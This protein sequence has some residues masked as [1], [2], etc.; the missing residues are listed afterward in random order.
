MAVGQHGAGTALRD[1]T[2][3][4]RTGQMEMI[5]DRP[6]KRRVRI[7]VYR[8]ALAIDV[9]L[10]VSPLPMNYILHSVRYYLHLVRI[11]KF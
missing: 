3:V 7:N 10:H 8:Q 1:P 2:A 5:A 11:F 6:E 4:F 9:E